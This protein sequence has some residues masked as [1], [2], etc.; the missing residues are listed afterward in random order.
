MEEA[1]A[2]FYQ[3]VTCVLV[4]IICGSLAMTI[5]NKF[6]HLSGSRSGL[7]WNYNGSI[8]WQVQVFGA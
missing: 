1:A 6:C 5:N 3:A 4:Q 2:V 8:D 7:H